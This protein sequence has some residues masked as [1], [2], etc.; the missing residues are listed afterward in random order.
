MSAARKARILVVDDEENI[1]KSLRM[2]LEY[3]GYGVLEAS[4]GEEALSLLEETLDVDLV[5]LDIKLPGRDGLEVLTDIRKRAAPPEVLVISGHGTIQSA[6]EATKRGAFEFLEKPLHRER[7][8]LSLRNALA[9]GSLRRECQDLRRRAEKRYELIGSHPLMKRLER[10][11]L[12]AAPTNATVLIYG[13][14]GTGKELIARA[15]H[16]HSLRARERFV[17]V[18]CAAIPEELIE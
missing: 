8:L 2:I 13:E 18:N 3:E 9:Q 10:D 1:R 14:S 16:N 12:K 11:I 15:V 4:S 5:F 17:Q 7:V 6:V